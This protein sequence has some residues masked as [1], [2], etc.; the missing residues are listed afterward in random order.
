MNV[1]LSF[2]HTPMAFT[3]VGHPASDMA[4]MAVTVMNGILLS[5]LDTS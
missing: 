3:A 2:T 1:W 4:M 5:L